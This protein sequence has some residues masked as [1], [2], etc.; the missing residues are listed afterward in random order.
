VRRSARRRVIAQEEGE[1]PAHFVTRVGEQLDT[2]FARG[3]SLT[4]AVVACNERLD[5]TAQRARAEIARTAMGAM[6]KLRSGGLLLSVSERS[7]VRLR[8]ALAELATELGSE[9]QRA[10]VT[11]SVRLGDEPVSASPAV[12]A[13]ANPPD[14]SVRVSARRGKDGSRKVA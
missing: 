12:P 8:S 11:A 5:E 1:S 6:A 14:M 7:S 4:T 10:E 13:A 9:W 3:A 2:L